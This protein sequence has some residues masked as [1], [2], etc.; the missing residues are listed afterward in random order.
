MVVRTQYVLRKDEF[1]LDCGFKNPLYSFLERGPLHEMYERTP[2][3]WETQLLQRHTGRLKSIIT[4]HDEALLSLDADF[5]RA[6]TQD[7]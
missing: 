4:T 3:E 6:Y 7:S 5:F 1:L 2:F